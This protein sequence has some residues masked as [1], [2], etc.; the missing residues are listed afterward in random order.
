MYK[1]GRNGQANTTAKKCEIFIHYR[2]STGFG[3]AD[4]LLALSKQTKRMEEVNQLVY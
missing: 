3:S 1:R 4:G 2:T